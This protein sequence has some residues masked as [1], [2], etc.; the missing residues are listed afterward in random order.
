MLQKAQRFSPDL[1]A[2]SSTTNKY[3][4]VS[5]MAHILK[6]RLNVPI[7]V[8]GIQATSL[9]EFVLSNPDIDMIYRGEGELAFLE[10]V[11]RM[12]QG[13]DISDV[14]NIWLK[15]KM[16]RLFAMISDP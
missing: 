10:L 2:F 8:G 14:A 1:V 4:I 13:K 9:P 5:R 3:P 15:M 7:I 11:D 6:K 12:E 16:D